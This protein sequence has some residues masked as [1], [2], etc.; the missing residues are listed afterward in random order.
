MVEQIVKVLLTSV[1][2]VSASEVAKR[3]AIFGAL[4]ASL[5]LTSLLAMVWLYFDTRDP[6][7]VAALATGI[8]WL[9]LPSVT[10]LLVFPLLL[11]KGVSFVPSLLIGIGLTAASYLAMIALLKWFGGGDV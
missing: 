1:L 6:E 8:F 5:P 3:S 10:F 2:V 7:K 11:R 9:L 4:I